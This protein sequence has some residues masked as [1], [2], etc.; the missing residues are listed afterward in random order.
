MPRQCSEKVEVAISSTND[1]I[2]WS[3]HG[4]WTRGD[5]ADPFIFSYTHIVCA[6]VKDA[7]EA[8]KAL[9]LS[10][11]EPVNVQLVVDTDASPALI[12]LYE[13]VSSAISH[14]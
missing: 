5:V 14:G 6:S 11:G 4:H 10:L 9:C 2:V 3:R 12:T 8:Q 1:A 13:L 7:S